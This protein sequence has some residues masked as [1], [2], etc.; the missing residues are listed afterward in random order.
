VRLP[1]RARLALAALLLLAGCAHPPGAELRLHRAEFSDLPGW[2]ESDPGLALSAFLRSCARI[3]A[4]PD[5]AGIGPGGKFGR[6]SDW[7][8]ACAEAD[9][10]SPD[11]ARGFFEHNFTPYALS[12][13]WG[14]R[15]G[16]FT[17]YYVPDFSGALERDE[18]HRVPLYPTPSD[19]VTADL[20]AF[21]QELAG[22][23]IIGRVQG[24][25]FVPYADRAEI[26]SEGLEGKAVPVAYLADPVDAFFLQIQGSGRVTLP[27]GQAVMIGYEG[28]N[29]RAYRAIGRDL[30]QR[31]EIPAEQMSMQAIRAWLEAHPD[32]AAE[33]M[34]L[35][36]SYVF[37]RRLPGT[38]ALGAEGTALTPEA[39]LAV[40]RRL[41][42][43]GA[44]VFLDLSAPEAGIE[45]RRFLLVA[46]DT[47]GAIRGPVRGDVFWGYGDGPG[48]IAGRMRGRGEAWIL[49]PPGVAG[50]A[51]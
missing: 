39:S 2:A 34:N 46:Q 25:S 23:K 48:E 7:K 36:P 28:A 1:H 32:Q 42:P 37:F 40:D 41:L 27:D 38:D 10:V 30:I 44:P 16:L 6:A 11:A 31:G 45:S 20:G 26:E 18:T 33:V 19:L 35:N 17:G 51:P 22:E 8:P 24:A 9:A 43:Y 5:D 13:E 4:K 47:G 21:R 50:D 15:E 12:D 49:L 14:A 3:A 29:G